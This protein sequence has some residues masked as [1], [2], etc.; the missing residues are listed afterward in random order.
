MV[1]P[2]RCERFF[3]PGASARNPPAPNVPTAPSHP[4]REHQEAMQVGPAWQRGL[5]AGPV[6]I[7][8]GE[9][10]R[11]PLPS[12]LSQE[13]GHWAVFQ[14]LFL[15]LMR[16]LRKAVPP[17][18]GAILHAGSPTAVGVRSWD[19]ARCQPGPALPSPRGHPAPLGGEGGGGRVGGQQCSS[20][21]LLVF[22]PRFGI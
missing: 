9:P 13:C 18:A 21:A 8:L 12:L 7:P 20:W 17:Q 19:H 4:P 11:A 6:C 3:Q 16:L 22:A 14:L 10:G 5:G 15:S 2:L 1:S